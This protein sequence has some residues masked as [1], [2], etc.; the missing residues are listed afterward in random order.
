MTASS[1]R[2]RR[3]PGR[4]PGSDGPL[5]AKG[6]KARLILQG[7]D[8]PDGVTVRGASLTIRGCTVGLARPRALHLDCGWTSGRLKIADS[9][10][11]PVVCEA[12]RLTAKRSIFDSRPAV[13]AA[14]KTAVQG[15][16]G[17]CPASVRLDHCTVLG[18][19]RLARRA[20]L[21]DC[22]VEG[23][24]YGIDGTRRLR[25][26]FKTRKL[27][28]PY[29]L[30]LKSNGRKGVEDGAFGTQERAHRLHALDAAIS[31]HLPQGLACAVV[32]AS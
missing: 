13:G 2:S 21:G 29:Y 4:D 23:T 26:K 30:Q 25:A 5:S 19:L 10:V 32:L 16:G 12:A 18:D 15:I 11:G 14:P 24:L 22:A 8:L 7:L 31:R 17:A 28:D 27:N 1:C 6:Q 9:I 3:R 20:E